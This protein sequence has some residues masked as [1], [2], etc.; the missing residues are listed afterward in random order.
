MPAKKKHFRTI[1][2]HSAGGFPVVS[3]SSGGKVDRLFKAL[4][5]AGEK[6]HLSLL[7]HSI[8]Q[9]TFL[10]DRSCKATSSEIFPMNIFLRRQHSLS[11][12]TCEHLNFRL[13]CLGINFC[14]SFR[15]SQIH[16]I[17]Q[18]R[19]IF[20]VDLFLI[21]TVSIFLCTLRHSH[22]GTLFQPLSNSTSSKFLSQR[23]L[24][25]R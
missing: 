14:I 10:H 2:A 8:S 5:H 7:I 9:S 11:L 1:W 3:Q 13:N 18:W 15:V 21:R 17:Y 19:W 22:V 24:A 25:N 6:T 20:Q 16:L 12:I 23:R 4:P